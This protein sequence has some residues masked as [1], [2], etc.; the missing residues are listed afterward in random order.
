M[1]F[2]HL[3]ILSTLTALVLAASVSASPQNTK[4]FDRYFSKASMAYKVPE[5][6]LRSICHIESKGNP[7]AINING[8]GFKP[9]SEAE[10]LALLSATE[11]RP[12]LLTI[13]YP[14]QAKRY[15]FFASKTEAKKALSD[16]YSR[17]RR[18]YLPNPKSTSIRKLDMRSVD[19]GLMQINHLYH[20][21]HFNA[22]ADLFDPETNILYA[23]KYFRQLLNRHG[24]IKKAV[25]H[26]HSN[27]DR[28]Q[29]IYLSQFWP[30]YQQLI[31]PRKKV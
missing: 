31:G 2:N 26:Y 18:W 16:I 10:A 23:A 3:S 7:W 24:T 21:R 28:Y 30:I 5:P 19:I 14:R 15:N 13:E 6:V 17:N 27:T 1:R 29:R 11:S 22:K 20:G 9:K 12:W 4:D 8:I 25:A